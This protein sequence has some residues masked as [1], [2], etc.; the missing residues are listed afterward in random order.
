MTTRSGLQEVV[1]RVAFL[2]ELG[3]RDDRERDAPSRSARRACTASH[4]P[5]GTVLFTTTTV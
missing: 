2:E 5:T 3:V 1:D 4:V